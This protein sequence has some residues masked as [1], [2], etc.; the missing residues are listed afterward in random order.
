MTIEEKEKIIN[1]LNNHRFEDLSSN[2]KRFIKY[3]YDDIKDDDLILCRGVN[4]RKVD[5]V[6]SVNKVEK[7]ISI[8]DGD[9]VCAYRDRV[10]SLILFLYS[11][12]ASKD[13]LLSILRYHYADGTYDGSGGY[14]D[15]LGQLL[16]IDF[17]KEI[18]IVNEEFK[19]QEKHGKVLEEFIF[20]EKSGRRVDYFYYGDSRCGIFAQTDE[21]KYQILNNKDK[22]R[23]DFMRIGA[24]NFIALKRNQPFNYCMDY[25]KHYCV[26]K[27]N[28]KKYIKRV[29]K[30]KKPLF[31]T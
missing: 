10:V 13:C 17:E 14:A 15:S 18:N 2:F 9:I 19:D 22:Y 6:I 5:C 1:S 24:F 8:K 29:Q 16:K 28:L 26:L 7:Y 4:G 31:Y 20:T 11:V 21:L 3:I 23:H 30:I 27:I 25:R 12:G